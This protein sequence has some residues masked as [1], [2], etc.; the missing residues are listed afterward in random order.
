MNDTRILIASPIQQSPALLREYIVNQIALDKSNLIVHY[1]LID[2]NLQIDSRELLFDFR[3]RI[4]DVHILRPSPDPQS[5]TLKMGEIKDL[6]LRYAAEEN[7]DYILLLS[8]HIILHPQT[9]HQ[10]LETKK[11][12]VAPSIEQPQVIEGNSIT[13]N[14]N[15]IPASLQKPGRI[16]TVERVRSC[17]LFHRS[18]WE[19]GVTFT[20]QTRSSINEDDL[21][22]QNALKQGFH[23]HMD[24]HLPAFPLLQTEDIPRL[25]QRK[26]EAHASLS[27]FTHANMSISLCMIVKNEEEVLERCLR[28]VE[29]IVDEWIIVD[30]GSSDRTKEIAA[31]FS[32]QVYDFTWIDD[33]SAARN[34]AF[35]LASKDFILW[36]DADDVLPSEHHAELKKIKSSLA[37]H[38]DVVSMAYH[39]SFDQHGNIATSQR[40]NRLVRRACNFKWI[41]F[42]HEYLDIFGNTYH[43]NIAIHHHKEQTTPRRNL[44]IYRKHIE[45]GSTFT[46]VDQ[47]HYGKELVNN[48]FFEDA[49]Q[50]YQQFLH[51][52]NGWKEGYI[53]ACLATAVC[54]YR[55]YE[56]ETA[57]MY[58][59]KTFKYDLPQAEACCRVGSYFMDDEQ[60]HE[61]TF[62][63]EQVFQLQ[64]PENSYGNVEQDLWT[65][66]PHLK[67]FICYD[68]LG[69]RAK[70]K[71]HID[72][73]YEYNPNHPNIQ[74][75]KKAYEHL[76]SAASLNSNPFTPPTG[77]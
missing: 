58:A 45:R 77:N 44:D 71:Y 25:Y 16:T 12:I 33:F 24:T 75:N 7:Y 36:L 72:R 63:F 5:P 17:F 39:T 49:T 26:S 48:G 70:A 42:V 62:W 54:Y 29:G 27:P 76:L 67:L 28:S 8:P 38:I 51:D 35:S 61:A 3:S 59:L 53:Y 65:W 19:K 40:R 22:C 6:I 1:L 4:E 37:P 31:Q 64:M 60:Y 20:D 74:H 13:L 56:R 30:T 52:E 32:E 46:P 9:L 55:M 43:S 21:F 73:A 11:E 68:R 2:L 10:L 23:L 41:G 18:V 50:V 57:L 15:I 47:Y 34:F 66:Y 14:S 69:N